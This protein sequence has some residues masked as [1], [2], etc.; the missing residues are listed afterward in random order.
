MSA[1]AELVTLAQQ[2]KRQ[3]KL[4]PQL[5]LEAVEVHP[6]TWRTLRE[7]LH[8]PRGGLPPVLDVIAGTAVG[9]QVRTVAGMPE[10]QLRAVWRVA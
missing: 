2:L 9:V 10:D 6:N 7:V 1:A 4:Q 5:V 8:P 3:A